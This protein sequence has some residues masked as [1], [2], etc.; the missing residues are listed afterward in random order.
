[1]N[2]YKRPLFIHWFYYISAIVSYWVAFILLA[3]HYYQQELPIPVGA[4]ALLGLCVFYPHIVFGIQYF[5]TGFNERHERYCMLLDISLC[6]VFANFIAVFST[7]ALLY[8][9]LTM[10]NIMFGHGLKVFLQGLALAMVNFGVSVGL[11]GLNFFTPVSFE[12]SLVSGVLTLAYPVYLSYIIHLRTN[13]L[14]R[15]KAML[16]H[17]KQEIETQ[18]SE[19]LLQKNAMQELNEELN[20]L[21][22][23]LATTVDT[24]SEQK[25]RIEQQNEDI[26]QSINYAKRIQEAVMP[27][28]GYIQMLL[29]QSFVLY[30]PKNIVSGDFYFLTKHRQKLFAAAVDCTGH[31]IPGAFM[32]LLGNDLL[33]EI[34]TGRNIFEAD[35]I[36]QELD[37]GISKILRQKETLNRDG[38]DIALLCIDL[39]SLEIS[40]AGAKN[41]LVYVEDGCLHYIKGD[42]K[43]IGGL[44]N[45]EKGFTKHLVR[46]QKPENTVFYLFSDGYQDQF[47]GPLQKKFMGKQLRDLLLEVHQ[48]P[49]ETQH[50]ILEQTIEQWRSQGNE[51]QTDDI[52]VMGFKLPLLGR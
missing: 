29:P 16:K 10:T 17:Q 27:S 30:K 12:L 50:Y 37:E 4:Y 39:E 1:M 25:N 47:G 31:G 40:F 18:H 21:N 19:I 35:E 13:S 43:H 24:I 36:L 42:S 3:V 11:M 44:Q 26:T 41:P 51:T 32:S 46:L 7:P 34:I 8:L 2:T 23:E 33:T 48:N 28:K 20:Q 49:F 22:E 15:S 9:M 45:T 6:G 5:K 38:M 14:K 52:L